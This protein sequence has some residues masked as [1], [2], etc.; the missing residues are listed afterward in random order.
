MRTSAAVAIVCLASSRGEADGRFTSIGIGAGTSL[1]AGSNDVAIPALLQHAPELQIAWGL[2]AGDAIIL[3]RLD[4]LGAMLP[5]GPAGI[6]LDVGGGWMP[7]W[8][9]AGWAPLVRGTV[10]GVMFGSGG[11]MLGPDH[12]SH[13]FRLALEAGAVRRSEAPGGMVAWG[14]LLGAQATGLVA[15]DPCATEH[16]CDAALLGV[17]ARLEAQLTF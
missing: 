1:Q 14:V 11:E 5:I 4:I 17:T 13:G 10:G 6:G 12:T 9:S 7:G 3:T 2:H 16:G 15:V 8:Q